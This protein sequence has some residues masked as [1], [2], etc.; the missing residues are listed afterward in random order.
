MNAAGD[1]MLG[2]ATT[3]AA[4]SSTNSNPS[5]G[6]SNA[7]PLITGGSSSSS[8]SSPSHLNVNGTSNS[9]IPDG[10]TS[11]SSING[12]AHSSINGTASH[13]NSTA[14][15]GQHAEE[16]ISGVQN[17]ERIWPNFLGEK[18]EHFLGTTDDM[19]LINRRYCIIPSSLM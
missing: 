7:P 9:V 14:I 6:S 2:T 1:R 10:S 3:T 13:T 8:S 5:S 17:L 16:E 11:H 12:S 18:S 4:S 19:N 15:G